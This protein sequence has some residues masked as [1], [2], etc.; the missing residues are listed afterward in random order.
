M[1]APAVNAIRHA[2]RTVQKLAGLTVRYQSG[3]YV[4]AGLP[5]TPAAVSAEVLFDPEDS[6]T[7]A[8][9]QD[10]LIDTDAITYAGLAQ[11]PRAG[12][13]ITVAD[14]RG[15]RVYEVVPLGGRHY[16]P[17]DSYGLQ[18]RIHTKLLSGEI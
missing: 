11:R 4:V 9:A 12:D 6:A 18:W 16:E 17:A 13:R 15:Q 10:W 3:D 7:A 2:Q 5:A 1:S 14:G 8:L